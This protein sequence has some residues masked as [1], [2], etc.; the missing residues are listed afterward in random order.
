MAEFLKAFALTTKWEGGYVDDPDDDGKETY[1]GI[2]RAN[3]PRW[4]GW[5]I[6]D[7]HKPLKKHAFI[8]DEELDRLV[9]E[10][11]RENFWM[12]VKGD[13][14][15]NQAIANVLFDW[16]VTSGFHSPKGLQ[17]VIGEVADGLIGPKSLASVNAGNQKQIFDQFNALREK[18][19]RDNATR[20]PKNRKFLGG[21]LNRTHS[22]KFNK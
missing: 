5:V 9:K 19:Y 11:Y 20:I 17:K 12:R 8:K 2:S 18:F 16:C 1:R 21:W 10:F 22:F 14:V 15:N 7:R 3:W 13:Q 4:K 6:V